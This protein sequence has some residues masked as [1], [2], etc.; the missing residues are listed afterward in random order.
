[1]LNGVKHLNDEILRSAQNDKYFRDRFL[2]LPRI[3][4]YRPLPN[5]NY[6]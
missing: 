3:R 6:A 2:T 1:M 5:W 4:G